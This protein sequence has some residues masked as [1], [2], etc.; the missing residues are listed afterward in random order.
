[1]AFFPDVLGN[2]LL[3]ERMGQLTI[4]G[5]LPHALI[6]EGQKG[7]GKRFF[8]R[9]LAA[10]LL[11]QNKGNPEKD[12]PCM[13]CLSCRKVLED[14][15]PD[16]RYLTREDKTTIGVDAVRSIRSD[17][18]LS[19]TEGEKKVYIIEE[20]HT[21]TVAAQNALLIVLEEPPENVHIILTTESRESLLTT[22]RSRAQLAR[23]GQL[24]KEE[25]SLFADRQPAVSQLKKTQIG[26]YEEALLA[27]GGRAGELL[28]LA[29]RS[30]VS[31]LLSRRENI[32]RLIGALAEHQGLSAVLDCLKA[33]SGK[34][35][36][37]PEDLSALLLAVR[38][39]CVLDKDENAP[40]LFYTQRELAKLHADALGGRRLH[41]L[42]D[43]VLDAI[44]SL[45]H[46]AN[47]NLLQTSLATALVAG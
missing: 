40:L 33:M 2:A 7:T 26:A 45:G 20:A 37:L 13:H 3:K 47:L 28:Y 44:E 35:K 5:R 15:S 32:Y 30:Q 19:S 9:R 1:M 43:T 23:M 12:F 10:A 42:Y 6:L 4:N 31:A 8:A 38:D 21:M 22:I 36:D 29:D 16:V 46:N 24:T 18:F 17:M 11:C 25:L 41:T 39:L 27:S 34:R 14:K